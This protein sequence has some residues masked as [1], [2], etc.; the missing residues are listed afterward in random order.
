MSNIQFI[1]LLGTIFVCS[2]F[3]T[4]DEGDELIP[5]IVGGILFGVAI[6]LKWLS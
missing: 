1:V 4:R 6:Y 3:C 5:S 2:S